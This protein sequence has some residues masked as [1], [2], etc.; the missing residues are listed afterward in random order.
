MW[1]R[2]LTGKLSTRASPRYA[3]VS[4][5]SRG[6]AAAA[7]G[8]TCLDG[9]DIS[10]SLRDVFRNLTALRLRQAVEKETGELKRWERDMYRVADRGTRTANWDVHRSRTSEPELAWQATNRMCEAQL[11]EDDVKRQAILGGAGDVF[12]VKPKAGTALLFYSRTRENLLDILTWHGACSVASGTKHI[13]Q[14]FK[15]WE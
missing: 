3:S 13:A 10:V 9:E 1:V 5:T 8:S 4:Y 15:G 12:A 2:F 11:Q 14:K 7:A 6:E